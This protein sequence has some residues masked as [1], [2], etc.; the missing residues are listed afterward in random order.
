MGQVRVLHVPSSRHLTD[1]LTKGHPSL[2]FL[3]F[4]SSLNVRTPP[5]VT[6]GDKGIA[7]K[8]HYLSTHGAH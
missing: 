2:L 6:A 4:W 7:I 3:D 8:A 1:I 5:V